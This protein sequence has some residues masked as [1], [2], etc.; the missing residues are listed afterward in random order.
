MQ[1]AGDHIHMESAQC[2]FINYYYYYYYYY[3]NGANKKAKG[4]GINPMKLKL[5]NKR[6]KE[7]RKNIAEKRQVTD[8]QINKQMRNIKTS[9][10]SQATQ[11]M[12]IMINRGKSHFCHY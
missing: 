3:Y 4:S 11:V 8:K 5:K 1:C 6:R 10:K 12:G 9:V 7:R 2:K